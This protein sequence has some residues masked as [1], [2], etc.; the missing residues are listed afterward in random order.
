MDSIDGRAPK[1]ILVAGG[2]TAAW[3]TCA[4]LL[5]RYERTHTKIIL[6]TQG[7]PPGSPRLASVLPSFRSFLQWIGA[8]EAEFMRASSAAF[9][10]ATVYQGWRGIKHT[11]VQTWGELG[12]PIQHLAFYKLYWKLLKSIRE[13]LPPYHEF[14]LAAHLARLDKFCHPVDDPTSIFSSLR[15]GWHFDEQ[16]FCRWLAK[17]VHTKIDFYDAQ[18]ERV[19]LKDAG[20]IQSVWVDGHALQAELFFDCTPSRTLVR[21][22]KPLQNAVQDL[23]KKSIDTSATLGLR[24]RALLDNKSANLSCDIATLL[25][26]GME[27]MQH[28]LCYSQ[29]SV[30]TNAEDCPPEMIEAFQQRFKN[31][32][33]EI[34][35][36]DDYYAKAH[37][38]NNCIA[39][40][41]A[42]VNINTPMVSILDL[43][44]AA[45][46]PLSKLTPTGSTNSAIGRH[47]NNV[48]R[49][50]ISRVIDAMW[51]LRLL[52]ADQKSA[53]G[54]A[55]NHVPLSSEMQQKLELYNWR[56]TWPAFEGGV[57]SANDQLSLLIGMN[58]FPQHLDP[59][60][61]GVELSVAT[62]HMAKL[63]MA[64]T[65]AL[66]GV[67][68]HR[69]YLTA[70]LRMPI[71]GP[72]S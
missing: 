35:Q 24:L 16:Q 33:V 69:Q 3:M 62:H 56:G 15:Y 20:D 61:E 26:I 25:P 32:K 2:G 7:E 60:T 19:Q 12:A 39:I 47:Y 57:V 67:K 58:R 18:I 55:R 27:Y 5:K 10:L 4:Y 23:A 63:Q 13:S 54:I 66:E 50:K 64:I 40:G 52:A 53:Y 1:R 68:D 42:S 49:Q 72:T 8:T 6:V 45:L 48:M 17:R 30:L 59:I 37:W 36:D 38:V 22:Q 70:L 14:S 11:H 46:E 51:L 43:T 34:T 71:I 29:L 41:P 44:W 9:K 21:T 65:R 31:A 28:S